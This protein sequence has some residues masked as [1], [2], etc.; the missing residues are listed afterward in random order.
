MH[1]QLKAYIKFSLSTYFF[2]MR[3]RVDDSEFLKG[4]MPDQAVPSFLNAIIY[5]PSFPQL[6]TLSAK[7]SVIR[8]MSFLASSSP[9][10]RHARLL[11]PISTY[12]P[13]I[14]ESNQISL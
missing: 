8:L 13:L 10:I 2:L 3:G 7:I 4:F 14:K 5:F 11:A 1:D 6:G 12:V 9:T